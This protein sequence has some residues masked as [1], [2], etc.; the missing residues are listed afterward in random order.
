MSNNFLSKKTLVE[1]Y[2]R[3]DYYKDKC[4][5]AL[6]NL[7]T[8]RKHI[9]L[10]DLENTIH[11]HVP[12]S[13]DVSEDMTLVI[14]EVMSLKALRELCL[15]I[16]EKYDQEVEYVAYA[17]GIEI[18]THQYLDLN[19]SEEFLLLNKPPV[20]VDIQRTASNI[21]VIGVGGGAMSNLFGCR[22]VL[23]QKKRLK[24]A[25]FIRHKGDLCNSKS[26]A[27][28]PIQEND[29]IIELTGT[30][31]LDIN[32]PELKYSVHRI[33]SIGETKVECEDVSDRFSGS[34]IPESVVAGAHS[35]HNKDGS[36]F[37]LEVLA[38]TNVKEK[39]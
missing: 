21:P 9:S 16:K 26:Q 2:L 27:L 17:Y 30:K 18:G 6:L 31:P 28:V 15:S 4:V 38:R 35:Y 34:Y 29:L 39:E 20:F 7:E 12:I 5:L 25:I 37:C 33:V 32:N 10:L 11:I 8:A 22:Y 36:Y 13:L 14:I 1:N 24:R 23:T 3:Q 19:T